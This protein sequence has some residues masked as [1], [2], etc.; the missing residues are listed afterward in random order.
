MASVWMRPRNRMAGLSFSSLSN[1]DKSALVGACAFAAASR[2]F[3]ESSADAGALSAEALA[4]GVAA[5]D[6]GTSVSDVDGAFAGPRPSSRAGPAGVDGPG[7]ATPG[8]TTLIWTQ[9]SPPA[10]G[11]PE[12]HPPVANAIRH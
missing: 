4:G 6:P 1:C 11:D 8:L 2:F 7:D 12:R 9:G 3:S 10:Q 5:E